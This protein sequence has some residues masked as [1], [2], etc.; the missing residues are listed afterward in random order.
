V[1]S[2]VA[3]RQAYLKTVERR[4]TGDRSHKDPRYVDQ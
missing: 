4:R 1:A 3:S 2:M